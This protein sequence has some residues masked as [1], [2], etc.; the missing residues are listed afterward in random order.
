[1]AVH[2]I[3]IN[4]RIASVDADAVLVCN[5]PTDTIQFEFDE[6]WSG[7]ST[8]TVRFSWE[9]RYIDIVITGNEVKV[10]EIFRT[11]YVFVGVYADNITS[12]P[13]KMSCKYSIKCLD[14]APT[15]PVPDV[16]AQILE[17][18]NSL[19]G[20]GGGSGADYVGIKS[21]EQTASSTE[22]SGLNRYRITLTDGTGTNIDVYNGK[23]GETGVGIESITVHDST[24]TGGANRVIIKLAD[25]TSKSFNVQN[26]KDGS[27][28][29]DGS[30]G[31]DGFSPTVSI[32]PISGGN[33]VTITD[34]NGPQS[35]DV[36]NGTGSGGGGVSEESDPTVP[37][38]AKT[39]TK[40][41][42]TAS[43]VG[44]LEDV[45][46]VLESKHYGNN[47]ILSTKLA[48]NAVWPRH[49]SDLVW[50]EVDSRINAALGVI[51]NGAY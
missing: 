40:P 44:A 43:E 42:Y 32:E 49:I 14:G 31:K 37:D 25:G 38:W 16:Y 10:P 12:T 11:N 15:A 8:K 20:S 48:D 3:A 13:V 4:N 50:G 24:I 27:T 46:G 47:S 22:S 7:H 2:V 39:E 30:D 33:R 28:G 36:M 6:E 19:V 29:K 23:A 45:S 26:G 17:L 34:A 51:E 41:K 18:L 5:N 1:M 9:G 21:I 35:F